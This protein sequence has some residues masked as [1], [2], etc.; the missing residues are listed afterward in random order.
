MLY[1]FTCRWMF[2]LF[3]VFVVIM[4]SAAINIGVH[5]LVWTHIVGAARGAVARSPAKYMLP[6]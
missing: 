5:I 4:N 6:L 2:K 1:P 3:S